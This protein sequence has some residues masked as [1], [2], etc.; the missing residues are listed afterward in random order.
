[1]KNL[2]KLIKIAEKVV[3]TRENCRS[4]GHRISPLAL[5]LAISELFLELNKLKS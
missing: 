5:D 4:K 2:D 3:E 1:M